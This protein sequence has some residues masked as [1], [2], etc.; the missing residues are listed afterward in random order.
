MVALGHVGLWAC[1]LAVALV[2]RFEGDI[3]D[4]M[5]WP[6]ALAL[7]FLVAARLLIFARAGLFGGL[8]RYTGFDE[9]VRIVAATSIPT[10]VLLAVGPVL[11]GGLSRVVL[12]GEWMASIVA[13]GGLRMVVRAMYERT[14]PRAAATRTL[15]VG[16][17]DTGE[18]LLRE[19]QRV[20]GEK[21]WEVVGF[22]DDGPDAL[23]AQ[24]HGVPVLGPATEASVRSAVAAHRVEEV[25]FALAD[26]ATRETRELVAS[27]RRLGLRTMV[28]PSV[29]ERMLLG[30][31]L[32]LREVALED[33]LGREPV[34]L[35]L[36]QVDGFIR[37]R[38][39]LV[40]GAGGSI[41]SELARQVLRFSPRT[42][43][44]LD[45]DENALFFI[46]RELREKR[47]DSE[48]KTL[49]ADI[50]D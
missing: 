22:L 5:A 42:L 45:H 24:V 18:G 48:L 39:V 36:E 21:G 37:G 27:C 38:V 23:G 26:V 33:L 10:L 13:V 15:V 28:M 19:L 40:T 49:A 20:H 17:N 41:G 25:V 14:R 8:F 9:L 30:G 3:P 29:A 47:G 12:V 50:T 32:P 11:I 7:S 46:E 16:V 43:I 31:A 2:L 35:D 1:A 44:T 6:C 4:R 34:Q